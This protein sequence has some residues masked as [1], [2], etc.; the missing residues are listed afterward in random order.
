ML[1]PIQIGLQSA[2]LL[3]LMG[4]VIAQLPTAI[5]HH[6]RRVLQPQPKQPQLDRRRRYGRHLPVHPQQQTAQQHIATHRGRRIGLGRAKFLERLLGRDTGP[7]EA[8][9]PG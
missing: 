2:R 1:G 7:F 8:L 9:P 6:A 3:R 5:S 4:Q